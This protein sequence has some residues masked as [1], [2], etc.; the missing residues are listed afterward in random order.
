[1]NPCFF[2]WDIDISIIY[3]YDNKGDFI[4]GKRVKL[5]NKPK[6]QA[7]IVSEAIL[8]KNE[9]WKFRC[10]LPRKELTT[11]PWYLNLPRECLVY[12][13]KLHNPNEQEKRKKANVSVWTKPRPNYD[14]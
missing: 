10:N 6:L 14:K 2:W 12:V 5:A 7:T 13:G 8:L 9:G 4:T 11:N 1:L 3:H